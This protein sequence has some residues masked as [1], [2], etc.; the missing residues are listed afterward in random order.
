VPTFSRF[1]ILLGVPTFRTAEAFSRF[2]ALHRVSP[3]S[4]H[5]INIKLGAYSIDL[6]LPASAAFQIRHARYHPAE[7]NN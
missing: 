5:S 2:G 3:G 1:V 4:H 7:V 6:Q